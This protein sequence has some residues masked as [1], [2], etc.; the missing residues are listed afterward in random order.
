MDL[1]VHPLP[2]QVGQEGYQVAQHL[3]LFGRYAGLIDRAVQFV[4]VGVLVGDALYQV[5]GGQDQ[6]V[7]RGRH[8][9]HVAVS[10]VNVAPAGRDFIVQI[11]LF[12][13]GALIG[14]VVDDGDVPQLP[15]DGDK[16]HHTA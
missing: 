10:V 15:A 3:L 1:G 4:A 13:N 12:G 7:Y 2:V 14:L 8:G 11:L 6:A 9:H 16:H 5:V